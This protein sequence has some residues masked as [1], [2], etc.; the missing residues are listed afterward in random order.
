MKRQI[1]ILSALA[2]MLGMHFSYA[3]NV[4]TV[5]IV[6]KVTKAALQDPL[7]NFMNYKV[8]GECNWLQWD[9]FGFPVPVVTPKVDEFM[10]D[11][12][13]TVF[14]ANG[15]NPWDYAKEFVDP[16][17]YTAWKTAP[18]LSNAFDIDGGGESITGNDM[19]QKFKEVDIV[20]YPGITAF[21]DLFPNLF[22]PSV[23]SPL[24]PYYSSILDTEVWRE[25]LIDNLQYPNNIIPGA[26]IIGDEASPWGSMF[27][28]IGFVN[29]M[30]DYKAA[31]V[32][33]L[34]A[35]DIVTN[36]EIPHLF[37]RLKSGDDA[38]G[39]DCDIYPSHENDFEDVKFQEIYPVPST[40]AEK[41]FGVND[42]TDE[43][44]YGQEQLDK[45]NGNYV[46]VMWRRYRGCVQTNGDFLGSVEL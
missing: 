27:P 38:C 37:N 21:E 8:V 20:G 42:V 17:A 30:G 33:A 45:G 22:I 6:E 1:S 15:E 19:M 9:E 26:R 3:D 32:I 10:P 34:R 24:M 43:S 13:I 44:P 36:G 4:S 41:I 12:V 35:A 25:P 31:A 2:L 39:H 46:F 16:V 14:V 29:Q 28:R 40:T 7:G 23:A 5:T 11:V 18:S